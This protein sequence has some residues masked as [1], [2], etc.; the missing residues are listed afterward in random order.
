MTPSLDGDGRQSLLLPPPVPQQKSHQIIENVAEEIGNQEVIAV[1]IIVMPF[2]LSLVVA[3]VVGIWNDHLINTK[4]IK[5]CFIMIF[6][7]AFTSALSIALCYFLLLYYTQLLVRT[8]TTTAIRKK[9]K[10]QQSC[11]KVCK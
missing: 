2:G 8:T 9:R 11:T 3:V 4:A 10:R 5:S 6:G 7:T 1:V